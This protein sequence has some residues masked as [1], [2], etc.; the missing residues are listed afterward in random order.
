MKIAF[1]FVEKTIQINNELSKLEKNL[2]V[3]FSSNTV[4]LSIVDEKF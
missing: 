2:S 1:H 3:Y 4:T